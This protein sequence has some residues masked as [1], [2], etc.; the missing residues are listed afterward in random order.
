M[1][2]LSLLDK[3]SSWQ[4]PG[5][6]MASLFEWCLSLINIILMLLTDW[7]VRHIRC[8]PLCWGSVNALVR[9]CSL[10]TGVPDADRTEKNS[11]TEPLKY[12]N[13]I[14]IKIISYGYRSQSIPGFLGHAKWGVPRGIV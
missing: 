3:T 1:K 12:E 10:L 11:S 5:K 2:D 8:L 6:S 7:H 13:C 4:T 9:R 14:P